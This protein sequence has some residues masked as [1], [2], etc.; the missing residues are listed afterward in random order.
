[1]PNPEGKEQSQQTGR[2]LQAGQSHEKITLW[3]I[4]KKRWPWLSITY[5]LLAL[6]GVYALVT[7]SITFKFFLLALVIVEFY[8]FIDKLIIKWFL[9]RRVTRNDKK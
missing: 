1:M 4:I 2:H 7:G 3:R 9:K 6:T 5:G 8:Q